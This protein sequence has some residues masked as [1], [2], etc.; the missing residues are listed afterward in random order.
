MRNYPKKI[1][2]LLFS[3]IIL[4]A[5]ISCKGTVSDTQAGKSDIKSGSNP[6]SSNNSSKRRYF[7]VDGA[8]LGSYDNEGWH[9]LCNTRGI[10]S[11]SSDAGTFYAKDFLNQDSYNVYDGRKLLGVSKQIIWLTEES[12]GLGCFEDK[13]APKKFEKY[14]KLYDDGNGSNSGYRIFDLPVKLGEELSN[15]EIPDY[16]FTTQ[17]VLSEDWKWGDESFRFVTNSEVNPFSEKMNYG[18]EPTDEGKQALMEL[19]KKN[20]ME[21]TLPNFTDCI[22]GDFDNDGKDEY[23]MA[24]NNPSSELGYPVIVG[25]GKMDRVGTF[26]A[27]LYQDDNN[28]IQVLHSDMRP[29]HETVELKNGC[30]EL[31]SADYSHSILSPTPADLNGD[32]IYEIIVIKGEWEG[33]YTLTFSQDKHGAY[34]VVMRSNWG[35]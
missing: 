34:S 31:I 6:D 10:Q 23:L 29:I 12:S 27:L 11:A 4:A 2:L 18:A 22:R 16:S 5:L 1:T 19:F 25:E 30:K 33:G 8:L 17:F 7:F 26:S 14:G 13:D 35:T 9:S 20:D 28:S 32:G 21:N 15:L 3:L 24:A